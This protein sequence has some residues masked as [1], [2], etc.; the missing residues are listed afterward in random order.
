MGSKGNEAISAIKTIMEQID[1]KPVQPIEDQTPQRKTESEI[2]E[3]LIE[4]GVIKPDEEENED[5]E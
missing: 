2:R 3:R 1:G 4:L 5:N